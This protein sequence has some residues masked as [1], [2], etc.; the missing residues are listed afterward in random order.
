MM[1]NPS[2]GYVAYLLRLW[3]A[4]EGG[5]AVWRASL[6]SPQTGE[7]WGFASLADLFTFL[8]CEVGQTPQRQPAPSTDERG[9]DIDKPD[10]R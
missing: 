4:Q 8:E 3:Q 7:R 6:E 2:R 10:P 1:S 9:G 5:S